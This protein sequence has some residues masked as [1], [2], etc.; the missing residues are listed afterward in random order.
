MKKPVFIALGA[1][2][3][4]CAAAAGCEKESGS[5]CPELVDFSA[6]CYEEVT[7]RQATDAQKD[8]WLESCTDDAHPDRCLE[9]AMGLTC[10]QYLE[11]NAY[12]DYCAAACS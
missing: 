2:L 12:R 9:C 6:G 3:F 8:Q 4:C 1:L 5:L 11:G 10:R 7:G